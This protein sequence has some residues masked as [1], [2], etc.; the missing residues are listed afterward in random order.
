MKFKLTNLREDEMRYNNVFKNI[1]RDVRNVY[2]VLYNKYKE[3]HE[4]DFKSI[5][6]EF[7]INTFTVRTLKK[8]GI[9]IDR[10]VFLLGSFIYPK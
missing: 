10:A 1:L 8:F 4:G 3:D 9:T 5:V 6:K 7:V 2:R